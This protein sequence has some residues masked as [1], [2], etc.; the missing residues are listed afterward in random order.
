MPYY[1]VTYEDLADRIA[2]EGLRPGGEGAV[3]LCASVEDC[4]T[5]MGVR[6]AVRMDK[7]GWAR[8]DEMVRAGEAPSLA[9]VRAARQQFEAMT[10][11]EVDVEG[12]EVMESSDHSEA[13]YGVRAFMVDV[14][15]SAERCRV[16]TEPIWG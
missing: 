10:V 12:L 14:P 5:L 9:D 8:L 16:W 15:V 4:R 13:F 6:L 11:V 2:A 3:F 1:H 7:A